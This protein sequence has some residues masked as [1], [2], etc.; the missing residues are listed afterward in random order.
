MKV[1]GRC[2]CGNITFEA[3]VDPATVAI[4]HCTDCQTLSGTAFGTV[5][6]TMEG[7]FR[8]LSGKP[9]AY[10]RTAESGN[11]REHTF[12]P[13]CGTPIYAALVVEGPRV[14]SL[15]VGAVRQRDQ[16]IPG[17][18]YWGRSAQSWLGALPT[19]QKRETQ[20][21]LDPRGGIVR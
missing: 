6:K 10:V 15:R 11:R 7:G 20:P 17:D 4:C 12:C 8:L 3:E 5:V 14:V 1:D 18:Q 2:H 13:N 21:A 9:N 16:M 19:T